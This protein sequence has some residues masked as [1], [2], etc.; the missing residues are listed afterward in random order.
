[1]NLPEDAPEEGSKHAADSMYNNI[2]IQRCL[3]GSF[4]TKCVVLGSIRFEKS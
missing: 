3:I 4:H 1:M 2:L